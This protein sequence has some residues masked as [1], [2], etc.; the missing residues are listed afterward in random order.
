M[1][2]DHRGIVDLNADVGEGFGAYS[3]GHDSAMLKLVSSAN[4]AC[5]FHAGDPVVL[6]RTMA[7]AVA[8]GARPGAHPGLPDLMG[9]GRREM[10]VSAA[11]ASDYVIYQVGAAAACAAASGTR[12]QHVKAHG[13][14][15]NMAARDEGLAAALAQAVRLV[16]PALIF[17]ALSGSAL[18]RAGLA[19]GLI[20]ASEVFGD[21]AYLDDGQLLPRSHP[22]A[23][24]ANPEEVALRVGLMVREGYVLSINGKRVRVKADTVCLHGDNPA[25]VEIASRLRECLAAQRIEVRSL[26]EL[27]LEGGKAP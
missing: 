17:V 19:E 5:G 15:Y 25:A 18:Y 1:N 26:S 21:R 13:A 3:I 2:R 23:V 16:D 22:E 9:F 7:A 6:R 10:A 24:I 8:A 12:L 4:I 27:E 20:T 11:E 14:L